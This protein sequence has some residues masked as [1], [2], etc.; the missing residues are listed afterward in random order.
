MSMVFG[1]ALVYACLKSGHHLVAYETDSC[2]LNVILAPLCTLS[3]QR[4]RLQKPTQSMIMEEDEEPVKKM[5]RKTS[6]ST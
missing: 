6:S 3:T 5:A 2:I 4:P 1:G